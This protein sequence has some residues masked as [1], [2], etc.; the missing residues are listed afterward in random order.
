MRNRLLGARVGL[1]QGALK[2]RLELLKRLS[3]GS[4]RVSP[5]SPRWSWVDWKIAHAGEA[6]GRIAVK[7]HRA[8]GDYAAWKNAIES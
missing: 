2:K 3:R 5:T 8:G 7:A 1:P 6:A 4:Y